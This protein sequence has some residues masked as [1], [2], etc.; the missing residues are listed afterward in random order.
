MNTE[1]NNLSPETRGLLATMALEDKDQG[2]ST[3]NDSAKRTGYSKK[4]VTSVEE[5]STSLINGENE[6][7]EDDAIGSDDL[8]N[9]A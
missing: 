7:E 6:E 1:I 4:P 3:T 5:E 2:E 8:I 9:M